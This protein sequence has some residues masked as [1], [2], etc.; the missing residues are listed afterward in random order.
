MA[1]DYVII[2]NNVVGNNLYDYLSS[3]REIN[4]QQTSR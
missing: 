2:T 4:K 1:I 3:I